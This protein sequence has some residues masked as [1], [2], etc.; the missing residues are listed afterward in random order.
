MR[1]VLCVRLMRVPFDIFDDSVIHRKD[2][3]AS[4]AVVFERGISRLALKGA[5][6]FSLARPEDLS[7]FSYALSRA[8]QAFPALKKQILAA[9][10]AC[11]FADRK[12]TADEAEILRA[13]SDSLDCPM[14]LVLADE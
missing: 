1:V 7:A 14:P 9:C 8:A 13:V 4:H 5:D 3:M 2:L 12:V 6:G 11:V 10:A